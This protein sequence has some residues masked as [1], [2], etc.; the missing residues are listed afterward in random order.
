MS[1]KSKQIKKYTHNRTHKY[2]HSITTDNKKLGMSDYW[3]LISL[4]IAD[5]IFSNMKTNVNRVDLKTVTVLSFHTSSK[6]SK[7]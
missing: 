4:N 3:S 7:Q 6:I 5:L 1:A 2:T